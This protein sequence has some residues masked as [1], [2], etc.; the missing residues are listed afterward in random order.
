MTEEFK[1][2]MGKELTEVVRGISTNIDYQEG[3]RDYKKN[4]VEM[5]EK[6]SIITDMKN[7][8]VGR[9]KESV[10]LG[11]GHLKGFSLKNR[12]KKQQGKTDST[13]ESHETSPSL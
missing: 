2:I 8:L 3:H 6:K 11:I 4:Q 5:L 1:K 9:K 7:S 12:R 13:E 10:N